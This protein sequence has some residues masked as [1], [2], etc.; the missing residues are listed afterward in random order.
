MYTS[1]RLIHGQDSMDDYSVKPISRPCAIQCLVRTQPSNNKRQPCS[2]LVPGGQLAYVGL[3]RSTGF[4]NMLS[5]KA[6]LRHRGGR[7][8]TKRSLDVAGKPCSRLATYTRPNV[9][10]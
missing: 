7:L 4:L 6:D 9:G 10:A 2:F 1:V 5:D 8:S 3:C